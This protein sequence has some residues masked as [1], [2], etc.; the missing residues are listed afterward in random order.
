M[1]MRQIEYNI[2]IMKQNYNYKACMQG[3]SLKIILNVY[4]NGSQYDLTGAK[5]ILNFAK[6]DGTPIVKKDDITVEGNVIACIL[7]EEYTNINGKT[8]FE[9]EINKDGKMTT[10]PLEIVIVQKSF[11]SEAVNNKIIEVLETIQMDEYVDTFMDSVKANVK[12]LSSQIDEKANK[13][14]VDTQNLLKRNVSD[15]LGATDMTEDFL[16]QITGKTSLNSIPE[17]KSVDCTKLKFP[18]CYITSENFIVINFKTNTISFNKNSYLF[19]GKT[20]FK[21]SNNNE[22]LDMSTVLHTDVSVCYYSPSDNKIKYGRYNEIEDGGWIIFYKCGYDIL[23]INSHGIKIIDVKGNEKN[24]HYQNYGLL[25]KNSND[26]LNID[27]FNFTIHIP[28]GLLITPNKSYAISRQD[29]DIVNH[30]TGSYLLYYDG[31]MNKFN[32]VRH[33]EFESIVFSSE[34]IIILATIF[35]NE[36]NPDKFNISSYNNIQ[37]NGKYYFEKFL[38]NYDENNVLLLPHKIFTIEGVDIALYKDSLLTFTDKAYDYKMALTNIKDGKATIEYFNDNIKITPEKL[39]NKFNI[40][41][42]FNPSDDFYFY[43]LEHKTVTKTSNKGKEITVLSIGDSLTNRNVIS[44]MVEYM[45]KLGVTVNTVGTMM[46]GGSK[47]EGR[48]GWKFSNFIGYDNT[49]NSTGTIIEVQP[50]G[51]TSTIYE[52]PFLRLANETDKNDNP[53]W[54]FR[55]TGTKFELNYKNDEDKS[56]DFYIFD[57]NNYIKSHEINTPDIITIAL[58]TNDINHDTTLAVNNCITSL[59]IMIKQIK[60]AIPDCKIGIVPAHAWLEKK[61]NNN[62]EK[63]TSVWIKECVN[64]VENLKIDYKDIDIIPMWCHMDRNFI[65]PSDAITVNNYK[66]GTY[67]D[68]VHFYEIGKRQYAEIMSFYIMNVI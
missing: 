64:L 39:S 57:F 44:Y 36:T 15:K 14:Y 23:T 28:P 2:D 7:D 4:N 35:F 45:K 5:A 13:I 16:K 60:K 46:N 17:D 65:Y 56:G 22:V 26:E 58:S 25:I 24:I 11:Q 18:Y 9:F 19:N 43:E 20:Y 42:K 61:N 66:K 62:W 59:E 52:N 38:P 21:V 55:N 37:V 48:E 8:K 29:I 32:Y 10:F 30:S 47:G 33:S 53:T 27:L 40:N 34:N 12:E 41:F 1:R 67:N 3:D 31:I 50:T 6:P 49:H 51:T 63:Y 68:T 54:C